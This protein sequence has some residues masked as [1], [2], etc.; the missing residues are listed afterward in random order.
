M[1]ALLFT[2]LVFVRFYF[3]SIVLLFY[4]SF[5]MKTKHVKIEIRSYTMNKVNS[6]Y[7]VQVS[8]SNTLRDPRQ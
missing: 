4:S 5:H 7:H 6:N 8:K 3:H 2:V 1:T